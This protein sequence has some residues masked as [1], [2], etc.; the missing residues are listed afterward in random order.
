[1]L[2]S[3]KFEDAAVRILKEY[4][5]DINENMARG[6]VFTTVRKNPNTVPKVK[7]LLSAAKDAGASDDEIAMGVLSIITEAFDVSDANDADT[8]VKKILE[9]VTGAT[10]Q[11]RANNK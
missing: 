5:P 2:R 3:A 6:L 11:W 9:A 7:N 1:M 10:K 4:D 8:R